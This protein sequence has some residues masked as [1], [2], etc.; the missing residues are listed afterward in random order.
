MITLFHRSDATECPSPCD[1]ADVAV[2]DGD[3]N[4]AGYIGAA[5][6]DHVPQDA[7]RFHVCEPEEVDDV[8]AGWGL[9]R[10]RADIIGGQG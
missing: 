8:L 9:H 10:P 6:G 1:L 4:A 5:W 3:G 7:L 2:T